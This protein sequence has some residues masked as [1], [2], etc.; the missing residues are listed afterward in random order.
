MIW[1]ILFLGFFLSY[2]GTGLMMVAVLCAIMYAFVSREISVKALLNKNSLNYKNSYIIII[3]IVFGLWLISA[4]M[5]ID[6]H[7][8]DTWSR[9]AVIACAGLLLYVILKNRPLPDFK[10]KLLYAQVIATIFSLWAIFDH[11]LIAPSVSEFLR[12]TDFWSSYYA[13]ILAMALPFSLWACVQ[14][15]RAINWVVPFLMVTAIFA[16]GGRSGWIA[17]IVMLFGF[18]ALFPFKEY[19]HALRTKLYCVLSVITGAISGLLIYWQAVGTE[20]FLTRSA[21]SSE[22]GLGSGRLDIWKFSWEKFLEN[23]VW[24][25]GPRNFRNLDFT[26]VELTS[27]YHPH[28]IVLELLLETGVMGFVAFMLFILLL[29]RDSTKTFYKNHDDVQVR[30][31]LICSVCALMAFGAASMTLTS[32]FHGW[33]FGYFVLLCVFIKVGIYKLSKNH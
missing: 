9:H 26:G 12:G 5:G 11:S 15:K 19:V 21:M 18:M 27:T 29:L 22:A 17:L 20:S 2:I 3:G 32:I 24:G 28:S 7:A 30:S 25:I 1:L 33:W 10:N 23:P 4:F 31:F 6:D 8:F 16:C 13:S 14:S